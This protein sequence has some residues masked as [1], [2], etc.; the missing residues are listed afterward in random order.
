MKLYTIKFDKITTFLMAKNN[1]EAI[2]LAGAFA[3]KQDARVKSLISED[4]KV[5][6]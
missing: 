5:V 4:G 2:K 1:K 3:I 6:I